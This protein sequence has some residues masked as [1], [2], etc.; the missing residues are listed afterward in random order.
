MSADEIRSI[1]AVRSNMPVEDIFH[2]LLQQL[3]SKKME[4]KK[5]IDESSKSTAIITRQFAYQLVLYFPDANA[6]IPRLLRAHQRTDGS[7]RFPE[8]TLPNNLPTV[9]CLYT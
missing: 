7:L 2:Y 1:A 3:V 4:K 8:G 9:H 6:T 5:T